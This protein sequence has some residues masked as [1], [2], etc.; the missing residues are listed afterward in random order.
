MR[1]ENGSRRIVNK[2]VNMRIERVAMRLQC[3]WVWTGS[4]FRRRR[5]RRSGFWLTG[6]SVTI[7]LARAWSVTTISVVMLSASV[8]LAPM[9]D[10]GIFV[11]SLLEGLNTDP[12]M[13]LLSP[14]TDAV[15]ANEAGNVQRSANTSDRERH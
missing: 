13:L 4:H 9:W 11:T 1:G 15:P 8:S 5:C 10:R 2:F 14:V 3:R 12:D 6:N 7:T